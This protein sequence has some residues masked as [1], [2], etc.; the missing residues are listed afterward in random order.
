[1]ADGTNPVLFLLDVAPDVNKLG[2]EVFA[3]MVNELWQKDPILVIGSEPATTPSGEPGN[4]EDPWV[5][6]ARLRRYVEETVDSAANRTIL[7]LVLALLRRT[8]TLSRRQC[9][10]GASVISRNEHSQSS[11]DLVQGRQFSSATKDT[12]SKAVSEEFGFSDGLVAA[13][14][15]AGRTLC[16]GNQMCYGHS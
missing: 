11:P 13:S 7:A 6:F 16:C 3:Q 15:L 8:R 1:M 9:I 10:S 14:R 2:R 12:S 4:Q 5:A